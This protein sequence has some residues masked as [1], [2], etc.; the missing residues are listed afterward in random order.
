MRKLTMIQEELKQS[1]DQEDS[2]ISDKDS[3][4]N[5]ILNSTPCSKIA[6]LK[7]SSKMLHTKDRNESFNS[8]NSLMMQINASNEPIK[9][10][11]MSRQGTK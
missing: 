2:E 7:A 11:S 4:S 8:E 6:K 5:S 10:V 3:G 9:M 1:H